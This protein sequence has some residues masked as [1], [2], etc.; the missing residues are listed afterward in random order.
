MNMAKKYKSKKKTDD[1]IRTVPEEGAPISLQKFLDKNKIENLTVLID[2]DAIGIVNDKPGLPTISIQD[3]EEQA[4]YFLNLNIA[5]PD[6]LKKYLAY[7]FNFDEVKDIEKING[8]YKFAKT[9]NEVKQ[10]IGLVQL[11]MF[12]LKHGSGAF[13][14]MP[15]TYLHPSRTAKI[16]ELVEMMKKDFLPK[17]SIA[18]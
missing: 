4:M 9:N 15:E 14:E 5:L 10:V 7:M 8:M 11:L 6:Y 13:I 12:C 1:D 3:R 16:I 18:I 17:K 2:K